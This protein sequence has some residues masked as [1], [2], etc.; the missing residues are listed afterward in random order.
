VT[1]DLERRV[2][3]LIAKKRNLDPAS[4][5]TATTFE[6]LGIDSLDATDL[7]FTFEDEFGI[8]V[9]D[10]AA[11]S[12]RGVRQVIDALRSLIGKPAGAP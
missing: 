4:I 12:M 9:P 3:D 2:I 6:E 5:T 7:L 8:V 10:E 11:R 1:D